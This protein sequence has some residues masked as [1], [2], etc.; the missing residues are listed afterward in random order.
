MS[1]SSSDHCSRSGSSN[2]VSYIFY[3]QISGLLNE[4]D[5][6]KKLSNQLQAE[7]RQLRDVIS[8]LEWNIESLKAD[9]KE[10]DDTIHQQVRWL[11]HKCTPVMVSSVCLSRNF[12]EHSHFNSFVREFLIKS[13]AKQNIK[14]ICNRYYE[15]IGMKSEMVHCF[16]SLLLYFILFTVM[17][18]RNDEGHMNWKKWNVHWLCTNDSIFIRLLISLP[19]MIFDK[20]KCTYT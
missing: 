1:I 2:I 3:Q 15:E 10:R 4:I 17:D 20:L 7:R 16:Q 9:I 19:E 8:S 6:Y 5:K 13:F 12:G 18:L 14:L 11:K